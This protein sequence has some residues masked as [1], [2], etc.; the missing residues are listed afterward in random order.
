MGP[1]VKPR[2][3]GEE[4][5]EAVPEI[6][7]YDAGHPRATRTRGGE[8]PGQTYGFPGSETDLLSRGL[9]NAGPLVSFEAR[10]LLSLLLRSGA[11]KDKVVETFEHWIG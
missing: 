8:V 5:V 11:S 7:G 10:V 4:L 9:I 2:L 3:T 1:G 6:A